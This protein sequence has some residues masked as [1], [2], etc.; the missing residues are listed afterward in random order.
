MAALDLSDS[1]T[2]GEDTVFQAPQDDLV[3]QLLVAWVLAGDWYPQRAQ[4]LACLKP[5]Y[6]VRE[7]LGASRDVVTYSYDQN[8]PRLVIPEDLR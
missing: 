2:L 8:Y 1:L 3:Y 6:G 5:C 4:E 7:R